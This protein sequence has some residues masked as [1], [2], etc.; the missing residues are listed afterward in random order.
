M[1]L[2]YGLTQCYVHSQ[3]CIEKPGETQTSIRLA[4]DLVRAPDSLSGTREFEF[5][6]WTMDMNQEL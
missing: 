4:S 1:V 5:P 3:R 2:L 6:V